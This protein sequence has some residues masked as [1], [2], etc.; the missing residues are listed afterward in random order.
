MARELTE[1]ELLE[2]KVKD[3]EDDLGMVW[4]YGLG[5]EGLLMYNLEDGEAEN[6]G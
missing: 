1:I 4:P 6:D 5:P 2:L 3:L